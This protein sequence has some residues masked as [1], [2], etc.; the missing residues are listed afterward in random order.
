MISSNTTGSYRDLQ[1]KINSVH[2]IDLM[3]GTEIRKTEDNTTITRAFGYNPTKEATQLFSQFKFCSGEKY[4]T[5]REM[6]PVENAYASMFA[7]ASY[8]YDQKYT[9]F[10]SVRYDGTNLFG[11]N[12]KY[13]YLPIWAVSG[14]WL[15]TKENL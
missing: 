12:K 15:V 14:S 3:A 11:V 2:E 5:Y 6:P 13:K 9:F 1:H 8:T 10:G 7:T 4:E